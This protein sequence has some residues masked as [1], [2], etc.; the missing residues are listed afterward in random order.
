MVEHD[1]RA[2]VATFYESDLRPTGETV[3]LGEAPAHHARVKRLATGDPL[4]LTNGVGALAAA[5]LA[6]VHRDSLDVV[7]GNVRMVAP[8]PPVHVCV[9][10]SDR[11]RMLWL[12]EKATEL[13]VASW[14]PVR[15]HRSASVVPRGE[16][17][18]FTAKCRAR[19]IAALEQSRGAWLPEV[20]PEIDV[21]DLGRGEGQLRILLHAP[22]PPLLSVVPLGARREVVVLFGPEGGVEPSELEFLAATGWRTASL[23][24]TVLRF[25]TAGIAAVAV[26]RAASLDT[27]ES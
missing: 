24:P 19:M 27:K 16:G 25:E 6:K 18:P 2:P 3:T 4:L 17:N 11:D 9:P 12:A 8:A 22:A 26:L 23:T 13:G 10:I 5:R 7:V 15:F 14:Q 21:E 20:R 1:D